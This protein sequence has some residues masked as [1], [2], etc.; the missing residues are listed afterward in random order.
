MDPDFEV[1]TEELRRHTTEA[2]AVADRIIGAA[3]DAPLPDPSP[4]WAVADAA[5]LAADSARQQLQLLG[6][7]LTETARR[8]GAAAAAYEEADA[9]TATRLRMSR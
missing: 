4:R 8:I 7:D 5:A 6:T 2:A 1:D 3:G 9:R